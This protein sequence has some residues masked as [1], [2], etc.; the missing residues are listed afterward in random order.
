MCYVWPGPRC[1]PHARAKMNTANR[2]VKA[3]AE[4]VNAINHEI[5]AREQAIANDGHGFGYEETLLDTNDVMADLQARKAAA[6]AD[7]RV[8]RTKAKEALRE[9]A[10][11]KGGKAEMEERLAAAKVA[12]DK[13]KVKQYERILKEGAVIAGWRENALIKMRE[14][15]RLPVSKS[16]LYHADGS[17][18]F[19][20]DDIGITTDLNNIGGD[21]QAGAAHTVAF[22]SADGLVHV[23]PQAYAVAL[24]ADGNPLDE[25]NRD[26]AV[27]WGYQ[28]CTEYTAY[29]SAAER[30]N[31]NMP[32]QE[33]VR[34]SNHFQEKFD[35]LEDADAAALE[36]IQSLRPKA[37]SWQPGVKVS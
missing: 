32:A 25:D 27:S 3:A 13:A 28:V 23:M 4:R 21:I 17:Y 22:K 1:T 19:Y 36:Y 8:A 7:L 16:R 34:Y 6:Q 5:T 31:G 9:Y 12:K 14:D 20:P 2:R 18:K 29:E 37:I 33:D 24:D 11:T 35:S 15:G 10:A 30:D 26:K